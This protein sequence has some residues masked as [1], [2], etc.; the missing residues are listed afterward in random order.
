MVSNPM[1][2]PD[3]NQP[4]PASVA[5]RQALASHIAA[6]LFLEAVEAGSDKARELD[7][8]LFGC[9]AEAACADRS[10]DAFMDRL[11]ALAEDDPRFMPALEA[12]MP[13]FDAYAA[14]VDRAAQIPARTPEGLREK[15]SLLL[16]HLGT[17][18]DHTTLA[19]S[20][21]RDITG[22]A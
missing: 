14:A 17:G 6:V 15:A 7:G 19:A 18:Q 2:A 12:A 4:P 11:D 3:P 20:L 22:R 1:R 10:A 21:A 16:L 9:C 8:E 5:A 13:L